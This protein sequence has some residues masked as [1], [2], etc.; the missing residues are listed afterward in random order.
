MSGE[1]FEIQFIQR[2]ILNTMAPLRFAL[3][4]TYLFL[5]SIGKLYVVNV[6][7]HNNFCI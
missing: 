2:V 3:Y 1:G 4:L 5:G 6:F 7:V